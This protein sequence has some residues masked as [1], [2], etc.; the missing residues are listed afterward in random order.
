MTAKNCGL[1]ETDIDYYEK[2]LSKKR[3]HRESFA[4]LGF[5]HRLRKQF[6][7]DLSIGER[8]NDLYECF[9]G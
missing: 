8:L 4:S 7:E 5:S 6:Q 2:G 1:N 9:S 3:N